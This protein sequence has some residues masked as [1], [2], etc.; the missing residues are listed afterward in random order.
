MADWNVITVAVSAQIRIPHTVPFFCR[1]G[2]VLAKSG[3]A[4]SMVRE[5]YVRATGE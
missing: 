5:L 3:F 2:A 1:R 4:S